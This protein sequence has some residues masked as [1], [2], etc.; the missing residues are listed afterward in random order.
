MHRYRPL[1]EENEGK[2]FWNIDRFEKGHNAV[3]G[4]AGG[5]AP[6][7]AEQFDSVGVSTGHL[8]K[9]VNRLLSSA[10]AG[11]EETVLACAKKLLDLNE[12]LFLEF[13]NDN[14][15]AIGMWVVEACLHSKKFDEVKERVLLLRKANPAIKEMVQEAHDARKAPAAEPTKDDSSTNSNEEK[16]ADKDDFDD[17]IPF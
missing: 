17:D 15:A 13:P 6:A 9:C 11:K 12:E 2:L 14:K 1:P 16:G 10:N 5:K 3:R 7:K 8:T 4:G